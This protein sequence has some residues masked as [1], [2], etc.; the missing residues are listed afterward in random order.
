MAEDRKFKQRMQHLEELIGT[1]DQ[2]ADPHIRA[3]VQELVQ[4]LMDLHGAGLDRMMEIVVQ[5]GK[6][7]N[8]LLDSFGQDDLVGSLLLV[9]GLH[10]EDLETRVGKALEKVRPYL[11]S[12]GGNVDLVAITDGVVRLQMQGNCHG[13]PSSAMTLKL[14]IEEAIYE[15]A[16]DVTAIQT[17]GVQEKRPPSGFV[18]AEN[19]RLLNEVPSGDGAWEVIRDLDSLD[20]GDIRTVEVSGRLVLFCRVGAEFYAYAGKCPGCSGSLES[21]S[22]QA[23]SLLCMS[24]GQHYDVVKAGRGQDQ[25]HLHLEPFPLLMEP[26]HARVALPGI[27]R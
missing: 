8:E 20:Q 17:E 6:S 18:P 9:Y 15:A 14:A 12:H 4:T 11:R 19:L 10:P 5:N 2:I 24:C 23:T 22:L 27:Q 21:A 3:S 16:P 13:C 1:I 7:A 25:P 26:G